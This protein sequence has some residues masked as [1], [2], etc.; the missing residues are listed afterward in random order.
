MPLVVVVVVVVVV[1]R[2]GCCYRSCAQGH[3]SFRRVL[4]R[5]KN[6]QGQN[7]SRALHAQ[8]TI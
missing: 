3:N 8:Y 5:T 7:G 4:K 6:M 2:R 1:V